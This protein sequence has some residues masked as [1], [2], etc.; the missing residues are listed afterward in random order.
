MI[1]AGPILLF[2]LTLLLMGFFA[3]IEMAFYN[4]NRLSLEIN[5]KKQEKTAQLVREFYEA[6]DRFLGATLLGFTL[7]LVLFSFFL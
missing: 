6:P 2:I 3:G 7:F 1:A 4:A 5:K